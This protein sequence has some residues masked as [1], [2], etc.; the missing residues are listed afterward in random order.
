[1][2]PRELAALLGVTTPTVHQWAHEGRIPVIR[3]SAKTLRF[4]EA[5]VLAAL[6][7]GR[8]V[9]PERKGVPHGK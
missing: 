5:A 9:A 4:D 3:A 2:T 8:D 7:A 1:M 6:R